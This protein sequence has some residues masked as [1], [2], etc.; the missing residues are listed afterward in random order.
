MADVDTNTALIIAAIGAG[1]AVIGGL[2]SS[3]TNF[4][5]EWQKDQKEQ[6]KRFFDLKKEVY[7]K[8]IEDA[9]EFANYTVDHPETDGI[10]SPP[11]VELRKS[12]RM[13]QLVG[14]NAVRST[15][16]EAWKTLLNWETIENVLIP[17]L[18]DDLKGEEEAKKKGWWQ[19]WR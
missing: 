5:I 14:D 13:A 19:I 15:I 1:S 8:L 2:I 12:Y 11:L 6:R 4:L 7:F 10:D 3:G 16:R 9:T 17:T 18:G